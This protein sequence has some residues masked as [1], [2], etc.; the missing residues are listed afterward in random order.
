MSLHCITR[1]QLPYMISKLTATHHCDTRGSMCCIYNTEDKFTLQ[2]E[3]LTHQWTLNKTVTQHFTPQVS[4]F[5][6]TDTTG[7]KPLSP[8]S[9]PKE[10]LFTTLLFR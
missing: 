5:Q 1:Q 7:F 6:N 2:A 8:L 10:I 3:V 4:T 9:T